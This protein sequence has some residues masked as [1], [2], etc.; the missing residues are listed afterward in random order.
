[1]HIKL[2]NGSSNGPIVLKWVVTNIVRLQ[3]GCAPMDA[4]NGVLS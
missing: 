4:M 2:E 1:V 3:W